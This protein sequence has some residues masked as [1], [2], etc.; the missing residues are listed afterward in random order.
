MATDENGVEWPRVPE[1]VG[2]RCCVAGSGSCA[3]QANGGRPA[4]A[5]PQAETNRGEP[6]SVASL[7]L[8]PFQLTNGNPAA[9]SSGRR[10]AGIAANSRQANVEDSVKTS[11]LVHMMSMARDGSS[12]RRPNRSPSRRAARSYC[13]AKKLDHRRDRARSCRRPQRRKRAVCQEGQGARGAD[14]GAGAGADRS[15]CAER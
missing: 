2:T 12:Y 14:A 4:A 6:S 15:R 9:A 10:Y 11:G 13:A 8:Q 5:R 3:V 1:T 7:M